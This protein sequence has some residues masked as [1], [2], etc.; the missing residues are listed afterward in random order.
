MPI[1]RL[2]AK[3][4]EGYASADPSNAKKF[5]P[6]LYKG[7]GQYEKVLVSATALPGYTFA[8]WSGKGECYPPTISGQPSSIPEPLDGNTRKSVYIEMNRYRT[9]TPV[10]ES[11]PCAP[12]ACPDSCTT[13]SPLDPSEWAVIHTS[14]PGIRECNVAKTAGANSGYDCYGFALGDFKNYPV[15]FFGLEENGGDGESP[16]TVGEV[17]AYFSRKGMHPYALYGE[18]AIPRTIYVPG[19][20]EN[21]EYH[22]FHAA[23]YPSGPTCS[24]CAESKLGVWIRIIHD[25]QEMAENPNPPPAYGGYGHVICTS[26]P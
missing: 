3:G 16:V 15:Y 11:C 23:R 8:H 1:L 6:L 13:T 10:F 20:D 24:T 22:V 21:W 14:F 4:C 5:Y 25:L 17:K 26:S 7:L 19:V 9:V 12:Y 18:P 2:P